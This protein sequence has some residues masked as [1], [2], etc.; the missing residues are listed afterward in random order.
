MVY[1]KNTIALG[2]N[3]QVDVVKGAVLLTDVQHMVQHLCSFEH[4][5]GEV[6]ELLDRIKS[7]T[8]NIFPS[9]CHLVNGIALKKGLLS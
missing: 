1:E 3:S 4:T 5:I 8:L 6:S 7:A 2:H 9:Y